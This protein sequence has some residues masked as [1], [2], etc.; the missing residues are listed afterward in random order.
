TAVVDDLDPVAG[1]EAQDR[2]TPEALEAQLVRGEHLDDAARDGGVLTR[3][4]E[5]RF[6]HRAAVMDA[7]LVKV[8][9]D[10]AEPTGRGHLAGILVRRNAHS[11]GREATGR[12]PDDLWPARNLA[13]RRG[14]G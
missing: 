9:L 1:V 6:A 8:V 11:R 5:R 10:A 3:P 13:V 7:H 2:V 4:R 12:G 14:A